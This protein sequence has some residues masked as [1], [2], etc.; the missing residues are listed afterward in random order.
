MSRQ[1]HAR[2][3]AHRFQHS[4]RKEAAMTRFTGSLGILAA[5]L[6]VAGLMAPAAMADGPV[7]AVLEVTDNGY[8]CISGCE[9]I[10]TS[11]GPWDLVIDVPYGTVAEMKFIWAHDLEEFPF[12]EHIF[13][14]EGYNL[15]TRTI[16]QN[17]RE[18]TL[19]FVA[20]Q[21]GTF[22]LKCD[23]DCDL[24][25]YMQRAQVRVLHTGGSTTGVSYTPTVLAFPAPSSEVRG[26]DTLALVAT[27]TD[28]V[29]TPVDRAELRFYLETEF[30]GVRDLV[31]IGSVWTDEGGAATY[32]FRPF[33]SDPQQRLVVR[34]NGGGVYDGTQAEIQL[35]LTSTPEPLYVLQR[36]GFDELRSFTRAGVVVL[37]TGIWALLGFVVLQ[38]LRIARTERSG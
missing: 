10:D 16:D 9:V 8:N 18:A 4:Q 29:G 32:N 22:V 26:F 5:L 36:T 33:T 34:F 37:F 24:H 3:S 1:R 19:R 28:E 38:A 27:L 12:E 7:H 6:L 25:N 30:A 20:D 14:L 13:R 11:G 21:R 17:N 2:E 23:L 31:H 35:P 15:A